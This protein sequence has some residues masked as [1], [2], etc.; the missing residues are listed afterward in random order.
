[1][2]R[3]KPD[4]GGR[5]RFRELHADARAIGGRLPRRRVVHLED[6]RR[7]RR[8]LHRAALLIDADEL[9][10]REAADGRTHA[11]RRRPIVRA[12]RFPLLGRQR[13]P[14]GLARGDVRRALGK[15]EQRL[16]ALG[17]RLRRCPTGWCRRRGGRR[18]RRRG[19][20]DH[21]MQNLWISGAHFHR[22]DPL[23][24]GGVGRNREVLIGDG[25]VG[26]DGIVFLHAEDRVRLADVPLG[27]VD[28]RRRQILGVA[29]RRAGR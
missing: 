4:F 9:P 3:G 15:R 21:V 8:Q 22:L 20:N 16:R 27:G 5:L 7:A 10:R 1:D 25:A 11:A 14:T 12:R 24:L 19:V 13:R 2:Q 18:R 6:E 29:F 17:G 23:V 26:R 28:R